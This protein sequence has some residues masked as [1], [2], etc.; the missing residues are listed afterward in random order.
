MTNLFKPA[1]LPDW[2]ESGIHKKIIAR[3]IET[4]EEEAFLQYFAAAIAGQKLER[5]FRFRCPPDLAKALRIAKFLRRWHRYWKAVEKQGYDFLFCSNKV[6]GHDAPLKKCCAS[7]P[8]GKK[9]FEA[10]RRY[11]CQHPACPVCGYFRR[12][13]HPVRAY[14]IPKLQAKGPF[15]YCRYLDM[16]KTI[17]TYRVQEVVEGKADAFR[18]AK[19]VREREAMKVFS[20]LERIVRP[21]GTVGL[22]EVRL[23]PERLDDET[24]VIRLTCKGV[25]FLQEKADFT[26]VLQG[27]FP[28]WS[29]KKS[30]LRS[31]E[32]IE[33]VRRL[34]ASAFALI[35][36]AHP[37]GHVEQMLCNGTAE[38]RLIGTLLLGGQSVGPVKRRRKPLLQ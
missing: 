23:E 1:L 37:A 38:D 7:K 9:T 35:P 33:D 16:Q 18:K 28:D 2:S 12:V 20:L 26:P 31:F 25:L 3:L 30:K 5:K 8:S 15:R 11:P 6:R 4:K 14:L 17:G 29:V 19:P 34:V 27:M 22:A 13:S 24:G 32:Q 36:P 10:K 21:S